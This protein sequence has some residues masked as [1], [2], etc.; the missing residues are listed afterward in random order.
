MSIS[1]VATAISPPQTEPGADLGAPAELSIIIPTFNEAR[2]IAELAQ[3]VA[4]A[5]PHTQ[6][7][8]I[9]VDDDSPD[10]TAA[11]AKA[12]EG[13]FARRE[14]TLLEA[15]P[16][17]HPFAAMAKQAP[18]VV[19][20]CGDETLERYPGFWVQDCAAATENLLLAAH[21]KGLGAVWVGLHPIE[22]RVEAMR[23][24]IGIPPQV[25][26]F[27]IVPVGHPAEEKP[28]SSRYDRRRIHFD[29]W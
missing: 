15:I 26:P 13:E 21:S 8:I 2:N 4:R 23:Q 29:R 12:L 1:P 11:A 16:K 14:K 19:L 10:G 3:R 6:W 27:A 22:E 5:L 25:I 9:V 24:L 20:V 28:A 17:V 7:E 18:L